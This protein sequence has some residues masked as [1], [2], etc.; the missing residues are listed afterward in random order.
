MNLSLDLVWGLVISL[1]KA[2]VGINCAPLDRFHVK[3]EVSATIARFEGNGQGSIDFYDGENWRSRIGFAGGPGNI[4]SHAL[5]KATC[6]RSES[7]VQIG[8][9]S[10]VAMTMREIGYGPGTGYVGFGGLTEPTAQVHLGGEESPRMHLTSDGGGPARTW[11]VISYVDGSFYITDVTN[12]LDRLQVVPNSS[13]VNEA[14][15]R[16]ASSSGGYGSG[17]E[18]GSAIIGGDYLPMGKIVWDGESSW[19][20]DPATQDS[21]C[22]IWTTHNGVQT[23]RIRISSV[24]PVLA[25]GSGHTVDDVIALLQT[26]G[27]CRQS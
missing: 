26:I 17:L 14:G 8:V 7:S 2:T 6:I 5:P 11:G 20:E 16:L 21:Y 12:G 27:W 10:S 3:E 1:L 22:T 23:K 4:F 15:I 19:D 9:G 24:A 25:T 13:S 18:V